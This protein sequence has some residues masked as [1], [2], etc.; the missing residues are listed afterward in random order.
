MERFAIVANGLVGLALMITGVIY[1][2]LGMTICGAVAIVIAVSFY[3]IGGEAEE[4]ES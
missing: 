2:V 4:Q 1:D 3:F